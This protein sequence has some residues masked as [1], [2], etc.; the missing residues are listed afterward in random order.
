MSGLCSKVLLIALGE[1]QDVCSTCFYVRVSDFSNGAL[2]PPLEATE[3][4]SGGH[5]Q[6]LSRGH[7]QRQRSKLGI[8]IDEHTSFE[9]LLKGATTHESLRTTVLSDTDKSC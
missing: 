2:V 6:R 1:I 7:E 3:L 8:F 9:K 5:V 4:F